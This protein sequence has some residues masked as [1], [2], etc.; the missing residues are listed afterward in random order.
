MEGYYRSM[1]EQLPEEAEYFVQEYKDNMLSIEEMRKIHEQ[2][3]KEWGSHTARYINLSK[4]A[5]TGLFYANV[6]SL[7]HEGLLHDHLM[8]E[9]LYAKKEH[10][11][12]QRVTDGYDYREIKWIRDVL[13]HPLVW[14]PTEEVENECVV[15][16]KVAREEPRPDAISDRDIYTFC[17]NLEQTGLLWFADTMPVLEDVRQFGRLEYDKIP[18]DM[19]LWD[20]LMCGHL[21]KTSPRQMQQ[22]IEYIAEHRGAA[23][24]VELV[25]R[26]REDWQDIITLRLFKLFEAEEYEVQRLHRA[27]FEEMDRQLRIW[28]SKAA[29]TPTPVE[30]VATLK[31]D[32]VFSLRYRKTDDYGRLL[33]FLDSERKLASDGDWARYALAMYGAKIFLHRPATFKLWLEQFGKLFERKVAYQEPNKLRRSTC[34]KSIEVYLPTW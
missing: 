27:M 10:V 9:Q 23:K 18:E 17:W 26:F 15:V 6:C 22:H 12:W 2:Q 14:V 4:D 16:G 33:D 19:V 11:D 31:L 13:T 21:F 1:I 30:E 32:E 29:P 5:N 25:E 24:A 8:V 7:I 3:Q 28:K 20:R 34:E